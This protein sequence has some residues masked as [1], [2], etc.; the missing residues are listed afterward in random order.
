MVI[1]YKNRGEDDSHKTE[2]RKRIQK[3]STKEVIQQWIPL[4]N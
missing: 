2:L 3:F 1:V 4:I